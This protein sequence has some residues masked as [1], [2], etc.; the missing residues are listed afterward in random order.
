MLTGVV[1]ITRLIPV[2][3]FDMVSYGAGLTKMSLSWFSLAT[4][5]GMLPLTF[6]YNNFGAALVVDGRPAVVV[7]TVMVLFFLMPVW[8][9][10][11]APDA[12]YA[13]LFRHP[14][15]GKGKQNRMT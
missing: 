3:S 10:R 8:V 11:Y 1:F 4:F 14:Q 15:D 2:V 12:R 7:G 9:E 5:L 6:V 13:G